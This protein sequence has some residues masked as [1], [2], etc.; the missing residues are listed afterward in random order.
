MVVVVLPR[1]F[2][3]PS[4]P[5]SFSPARPRGIP[6]LLEDGTAQP[7]VVGVDSGGAAAAEILPPSFLPI[8]GGTTPRENWA[9]YI[10]QLWLLLVAV[11]VVEV[12]LPRRR[13]ASL[14]PFGVLV[15]FVTPEGLPSFSALLAL[16]LLL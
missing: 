2:L 1:P 16:P 5:H 11:V 7:V 6:I 13:S 3:P 8:Y 14:F 9:A 10:E 12:V 4:L 15:A